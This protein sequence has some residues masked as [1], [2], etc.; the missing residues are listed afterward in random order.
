MPGMDI[1][2]IT[3]MKTTAQA[4]TTI[5]TT[6]TKTTAQTAMDI[7]TMETK[8]MEQMAITIIT[9]TPTWPASLISFPTLT[10]NRR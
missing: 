6:G 9:T 5:I 8:N 2:I 1:T 4:A 3:G 7:T 10:W